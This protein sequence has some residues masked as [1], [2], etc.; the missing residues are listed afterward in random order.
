MN[1]IKLA[2]KRFNE[3]KS[4]FRE[5]IIEYLSKLFYEGTRLEDI[6]NMLGEDKTIFTQNNVSLAFPNYD[7]KEFKTIGDFVNKA[8]GISCLIYDDVNDLE[9]YG[10]IFEVIY[11][12]ALKIAIEVTGDLTSKMFKKAFDSVYLLGLKQL[13]AMFDESFDIVLN[14]NK[15]IVRFHK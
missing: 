4:E 12:F 7:P 9:Y 1:T 5:L 3:R 11:L 10:D 15:K 8:N 14:F 2:E 13:Q 6:S